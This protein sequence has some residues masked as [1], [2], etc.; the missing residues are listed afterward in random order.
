MEMWRCEDVEW[1]SLRYVVA[2]PGQEGLGNHGLGLA[3]FAQH[4]RLTMLTMSVLCRPMHVAETWGWTNVTRRPSWPTSRHQ[5]D[6]QTS[7]R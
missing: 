2:V 3:L 6:A 5:L 1:N 7:L 4:N